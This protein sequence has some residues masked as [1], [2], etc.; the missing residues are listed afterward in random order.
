M[1]SPR[2]VKE[3]VYVKLGRE[4]VG[5]DREQTKNCRGEDERR[6]C[7]THITY[8]EKIYKQISQI[9]VLNDE[10]TGSLGLAL[11]LDSPQ[12]S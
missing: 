8:I 5:G 6:I 4:R 2:L 7:S 9:L 3:K 11:C 10:S 12:L 1:E